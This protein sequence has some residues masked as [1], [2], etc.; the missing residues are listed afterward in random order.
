MIPTA[1]IARARGSSQLLHPP[2][3][4]ILLILDRI[5]DVGYTSIYRET[6]DHEL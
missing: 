5:L 1:R 2:F 3:F 6:I 4:S